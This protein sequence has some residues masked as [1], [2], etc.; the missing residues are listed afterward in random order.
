M[1]IE[2]GMTCENNM[3]NNTSCERI[4]SKIRESDINNETIAKE[5][6]EEKRSDVINDTVTEDTDRID[7]G[8]EKKFVEKGDDEIHTSKIEEN[9]EL[10]DSNMQLI[11][12]KSDINKSRISDEESILNH[13]EHE[14]SM[15]SNMTGNQ[16]ID[17]KDVEATDV[18]ETMCSEN[19]E[20]YVCKKLTGNK[21]KRKL[22][23]IFPGCNKTFSRPDKLE[24]HTLFHSN[25]RDFVCGMI[26]CGK[27]YTTAQYLR[28][29]HATAHAEPDPSKEI[30]PGNYS[31]FV[32]CDDA[33]CSRRF[34]TKLAM[35]KH[36][37]KIHL[38][39]RARYTCEI[40]FSSFFYQADYYKHMYAEHDVKLLMC[41]KCDL[42][43]SSKTDMNRHMRGHRTWTCEEPQCYGIVFEKYTEKRKHDAIVHPILYICHHCNFQAQRKFFLE[44]HMYSKHLPS[45]ERPMLSCTYE[46][47]NKTF[48]HERNYLQHYK[49]KHLNEATLF[50]CPMGC[51]QTFATKQSCQRHVV[52]IHQGADGNLVEKTEPDLPFSCDYCHKKFGKQLNVR[53]HVHRVHVQQ[54][55]RVI[56]K[57]LHSI[58]EPTEVSLPPLLPS[59]YIPP[60]EDSLNINSSVDST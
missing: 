50:V 7:D 53:R 12:L 34:Q 57:I 6:Q 11:N 48:H 60:P 44:E 17:V 39:T 15:T 31:G 9:V 26:S 38:N 42:I 45:N 46:N 52:K 33:T 21:L 54:P 49:K 8:C 10:D 3:A 40:C 59:K 27:A 5:K 51:P 20:K 35:N 32:P 4:A 37:E 41:H 18:V 58:F 19:E 2:D 30:A 56:S 43:F 23:C 25:V 55:R 47:C 16:V 14:H 36:Y 22:P 13:V 24:K 28:R 1:E 29:H